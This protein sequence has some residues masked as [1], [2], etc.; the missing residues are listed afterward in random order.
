MLYVQIYPKRHKDA[1]IFSRKDSKMDLKI[2][3]MVLTNK[4]VLF[5]VNYLEFLIIIFLVIWTSA[6]A[7]KGAAVFDKM[8]ELC[9]AAV[10]TLNI[11]KEPPTYHHQTNILPKTSV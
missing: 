10:S 8:T 5:M 3:F 1:P 4:S 7:E 2:T 6:E 9:A 11:T